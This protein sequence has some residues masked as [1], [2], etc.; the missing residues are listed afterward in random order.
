M[1]KVIVW[2]FVLFF[3]ACPVFA[4]TGINSCQTLNSEGERYFLTGNITNS[5]TSN[6][7]TVGVDSVEL[8]MAGFTIDG[9]DVADR[10]FYCYGYTNITLRNG[11]WQDWDT[12]TLNVRGCHD[13][14][15]D[16]LTFTSN[17]D[18][19]LYS[20]STY[21]SNFTNWTG[22]GGSKYFKFLHGKYGDKILFESFIVR[23]PVNIQVQ[24]VSQ[25]IIGCG[26]F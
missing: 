22:I 21:R 25:K 19:W 9:D 6:C 7:I 4:D 2:A 15:F 23:D 11:T 5:G 8:D 18:R 17:T 12:W 1:G 20:Y 26:S 13:S 16:N 10:G 3:L 24:V 14:L